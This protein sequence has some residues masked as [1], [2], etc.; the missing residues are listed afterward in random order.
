MEEFVAD[1]FAGVKAHYEARTRN[2]ENRMKEMERRM[3]LLD[4]DNKSLKSQNKKMIRR[5]EQGLH[6][7]VDSV[8]KAAIRP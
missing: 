1:D 7:Y 3:A 6:S 2:L 8:S 4:R 5:S